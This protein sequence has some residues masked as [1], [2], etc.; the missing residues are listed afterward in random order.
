MLWELPSLPGRVFSVDITGDGRT[1]AAGSSLDGHGHVHVYRM[2]PAPAIPDADSGDPQ[3]AG[4]S[5]AAAKRNRSCRSILSRA[6]KTLAK[7]EVA[8]GGVYAVALSPGGDRVAAAGGDGTV[9]LFDT[10]TGSLVTS[11]VPVEISKARRC[12]TRSRRPP[13]RMPNRMSE[14]LGYRRAA[15][16]GRRCGR[17]AWSLSPSRFNWMGRRDTRS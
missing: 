5:T 12:G 13:R 9:R 3:Q 2:E 11:F 10:Q 7:V 1:I 15:A 16:A 6:C 14:T 4:A 17:A 8:E